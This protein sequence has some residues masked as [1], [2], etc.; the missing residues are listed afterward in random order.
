M[1]VRAY[2]LLT[3]RLVTPVAASAWTWERPLSGAGNMSVTVA[4]SGEAL[5]QNLLE[6]ARA[7]RTVLVDCD[8]QTDASGARR[9]VCHGSGI[10]YQR[11]FTTKE[12]KFTCIGF[13]DLFKALLVINSALRDAEVHGQIIDPDTK[14]VVVPAEWR[15]HVSGSTADMLIQLIQLALSWQNLPVILPSQTGGSQYRDYYGTDLATVADR[16]QDV[17]NLEGGPEWVWDPVVLGGLLFHE[18][19]VG[20]T[21]LDREHWSI[22]ATVDGAPATDVT[23][24]EDGAGMSGDAWAAGGKQDDKILM[25][26]THDSLLQDLGWPRLM[27]VVTGHDSVSEVATLDRYT[28]AATNVGRRPSEVFTF[29]VLR[30]RW[31]LQPGDWV[32]L[33][34]VSWFSPAAKKWALKVLQVSGDETGWTTVS[35]RERV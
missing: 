13:A 18:L 33:K 20:H 23:Y 8:W 1:A 11:E 5:A 10:V 31:D 7:W 2:D 3:G 16:V 25:S 24:T 12:A 29:K 14:D 28:R 15:V 4:G 32:D 34:W 19:S 17:T 27:S 30:A 22:D 6:N 35:T 21:E 9:L 26:R